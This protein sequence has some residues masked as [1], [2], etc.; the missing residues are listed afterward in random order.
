MSSGVLEIGLA[1]PVVAEAETRPA[2]DGSERVL[3]SKL[4][5]RDPE[6]FEALVRA[7]Q[8][9]VYNFCLRM[10]NDREE[11]NDLVQ[12]IFVSIHQ[13]LDKFRMDARLSTWILRIARNHCLNRLKYL[14]RR[15]RGRSDAFT[16]VSEGA[17]QDALDGPQKPDEALNAAHERD[18]VRRAIARLD[19]EQRV[20]VVL[21]DIEQMTYEEIIEIT[22]LAEG[23]VKSRLHR[24]REKLATII[25]GLEE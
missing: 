1:E 17:L 14:K 8:D 24:A 4:R 10:L 11:A 15:G 3:V 12:E 22:D 21:R 18:L 23:T 25:A 20:L 9:R 13:N 6:A 5:R 16:D 19:E 2:P 7:H